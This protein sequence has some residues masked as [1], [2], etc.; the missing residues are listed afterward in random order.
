MRGFA[1]YTIELFTAMKQLA[2]D[3]LELYSFSPEPLSAR[4]KGMLPLTPIVFASSRE[5]LWEQVELPKQLKQA[6]IDV[7]HATANRGLPW[8]R[9]CKYVV[10]VHDV[11]DRLPAYTKGEYWR[12]RLR[13]KYSDAISR[14]SADR[15]I[16]V[17][18]FSKQD[19]CRFHHLPPSRVTVVYNAAG[20]PFHRHVPPEGLARVREIACR[21]NTSSSSAASIAART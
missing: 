1:R 11:I 7:F 14:H 18:E 6:N 16:T 13:K 17:S 10:T 2:G 3:R 4:F 20:E 8:Q 9:A 21:A 15:Y 12:G 19:I 5:I